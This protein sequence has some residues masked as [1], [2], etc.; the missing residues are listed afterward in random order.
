[1]PTHKKSLGRNGKIV[2][3]VIFGISSVVSCGVLFGSSEE[4]VD[5]SE[6]TE[7]E[8]QK[9]GK[10]QDSGDIKLWRD[11]I[12]YAIWGGRVTEE[13]GKSDRRSNYAVNAYNF[14]LGIVH[15]YEEYY[16]EDAVV[17]YFRDVNSEHINRVRGIGCEIADKYIKKSNTLDHSEAPK[18][19][20]AYKE[21]HCKEPAP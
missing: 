17:S 2:L 9:T 10:E 19:V 20:L 6:F 1:M 18:D 7:E 5:L 8:I 21:R 15:H 12:M 14:D 4:A 3:S 13:H 11:G 16:Y